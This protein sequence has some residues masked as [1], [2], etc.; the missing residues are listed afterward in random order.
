MDFAV[1]GISIAALIVGLVEFAKGQGIEGRASQ[2]LAFVLGIALMAIAYGIDSGLIPAV[3]VP[4][5]QWAVVAIAGG[6]A[7][8]GYYDLA[9]KLLGKSNG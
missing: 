3:A 5:V 7:A 6:P 9:K 1:A 8:M 2:I 4:Y